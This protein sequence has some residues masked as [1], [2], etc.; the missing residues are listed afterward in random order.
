MNNQS[1]GWQNPIPNIINHLY[2]DGEEV[3]Y[4]AQGGAGINGSV[5]SKLDRTITFRIVNLGAFTA[6]A[7][8][9]GSD[10]Q[11]DFDPFFGASFIAMPDLADPT[12]GI[13]PG[14]SRVRR[15]AIGNPF[16]IS[17]IKMFFPNAVP[18]IISAQ[19]AEP[20]RFRNQSIYGKNE[21]LV[22]QTLNAISPT[23]ANNAYIDMPEAG[24]EID[25]RSDVLYNILPGEEVW[26]YFTVKARL[27][28]ADFL[29]AANP[30]IQTSIA[31]RPTGNPLY[32][33]VADYNKEKL[34]GITHAETLEASADLTPGI[35][36]AQPV[37]E[38]L[39]NGTVPPQAPTN[40]PQ[41]MQVKTLD[42]G[43]DDCM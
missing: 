35:P 42:R 11:P 32:D 22:L 28:G 27:N 14:Q 29:F 18:G 41:P 37:K 33:I 30:K 12:T 6:G 16:S 26:I 13:I 21:V 15:E 9:F 36:P 7:I 4:F 43:E 19:Q 34:F 25:P 39:P 20:L 24:V 31:P 8:L 38:P 3:G 5:L 1:S 17:G 10:G 2:K 40:M 23:N